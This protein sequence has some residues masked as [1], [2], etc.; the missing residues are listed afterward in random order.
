M[1]PQTPVGPERGSREEGN[2]QRWTEKQRGREEETKG[3]VKGREKGGRWNDDDDRGGKREES[4]DSGRK[5]RAVRYFTLL[6]FQ[7]IKFSEMSVLLA[8]L[9]SGL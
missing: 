5:T 7:I 8:G 9:H 3:K 6:V 2:R 4:R 1:V